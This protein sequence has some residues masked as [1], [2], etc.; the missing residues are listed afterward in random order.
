VIR[1]DSGGFLLED[2]SELPQVPSHVRRLYADFETS[3]GNPLVKSTNPWRDCSVIGASV[4]FD[5][6]PAWFVPKNLLVTGWWRDVLRASTDWVNHNVKYDAHVSANDLSCP[7]PS[8]CELTCT[9]TKAKLIDSDRMF[10]GGYGL[11]ALSQ[12]WL[13][14]D[15][16]EYEWR[17]SPYLKRS[18]DYGDV[19]L[20]VL[21]EY[22]CVDATTC[23]DL[24]AYEAKELPE[25]SKDVAATERR[26]T[27]IL[28]EIERRGL[29]VD[30][31][32]LQL[33]QLKVLTRMYD[34]DLALDK[35]VGRSFRAHV[36]DD[37]Y[38]VLCNQFGLPVLAWTEPTSEVGVPGPSFDKHA[39]ALYL[40][41]PSAPVDLIEMMLEYRKLSTF[42]SLFLSQWESLVGPDGA[43]H[44]TFNQCVR[45]GRMSCSD[46]NM[47]QFDLAAKSLIVPPPGYVIVVSD[48][49][50]IEFRIIVHY[51]GNQRCIEA[52]AADP[53][54][55]FHQWVADM[56]PTARKPAKTLNFM[57]GYGGGRAKAV[58]MLS[59]NRDVVGDVIAEIEASGARDEVRASMIARACERRGQEV[60]DRYHSALAE[61]KP[62]SRAADAACRKRG[63]A[64]NWYGR[65]RHLPYKAAHKAFNSVC[66]STAGDMVKE[67]MVALRDEVPEF[68]M[69]GQ[70]HDELVGIVRADLLCDD[71]L[72]R[73]TG[74]LSSP[75]RPLDVPV[76]WTIGHSAENWAAAKEMELKL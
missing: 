61:L 29:R 35:R 72:R 15:I 49:S 59:I 52:Y 31:T 53:W 48:A 32:Q 41:H 46:P 55:D 14:R 4:A 23:R 16:S 63:Y 68:E 45:T 38:D 42:N 22:A 62:T 47:Q 30:P 34:L 65:R 9:L 3:S 7:I 74:V 2:A 50:Q 5:D 25:E 18:R 57:M 1:F 10:R 54:T 51:I 60:Y 28:W 76:R 43:L 67:R 36:N 8:T 64:R 13:G 44:S 20:D 40:N 6:S 11:D 21:A 39:L 73:V 24:D 58:A 12:A 26:V 75:S 17:M 56:V 37:C 19:A 70:V 71:L 66:Q 69:V 33:T 27:K